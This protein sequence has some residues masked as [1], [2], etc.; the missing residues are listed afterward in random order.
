M[1]NLRKGKLVLERME[2]K[3]IRQV[4]EAKLLSSIKNKPGLNKLIP[5]SL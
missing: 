2:I 1:L 3:R 5:K 4:L